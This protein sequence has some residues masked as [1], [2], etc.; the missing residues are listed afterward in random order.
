VPSAAPFIDLTVLACLA[1][2][3]FVLSVLYW[4]VAAELAALERLL[5][6]VLG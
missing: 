4:L 1:A 6:T 3:L 2:F 5:R